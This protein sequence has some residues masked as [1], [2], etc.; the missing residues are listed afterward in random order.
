MF[1]LDTV[2]P[3]IR[4][5]SLNGTTSIPDS[6]RSPDLKFYCL[7]DPSKPDTPLNWTQNVN[8]IG[9]RF[10]DVS[11]YLGKFGCDPPPHPPPRPTCWIRAC[12]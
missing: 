10:R 6:S 3:H 7:F 5:P 11:L 8:P 12:I 9:V 2:K 1:T 4:T